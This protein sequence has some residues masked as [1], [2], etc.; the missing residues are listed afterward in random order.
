MT[1]RGL[2]EAED[3]YIARTEKEGD[4]WRPID[5]TQDS[6]NDTNVGDYEDEE[7]DDEEEIVLDLP[8]RR[9]ERAAAARAQ[10]DAEAA[11]HDPSYS[12]GP[13]VYGPLLHPG[14]VFALTPG[15]YGTIET[16]I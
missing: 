2:K 15:Y 5:L 6:E 14:T 12:S 16:E 9:A 1:V 3:Y 13:P 11:A 10:Q 7:E 4:E 8:R